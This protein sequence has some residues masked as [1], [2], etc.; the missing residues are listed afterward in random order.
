MNPFA[1]RFPDTCKW[2]LVDGYPIGGG[3]QADIYRVYNRDGGSEVYALKL[4]KHSDQ[5]ARSR[6]HREINA[7]KNLD[8]PRVMKV[9]DS[10]TDGEE[11]Q[12]YVMPF[13]YGARPLTEVIKSDSNPFK[14]DAVR[15]IQMFIQIL[16]GLQECHTKEIVHRDLSPNNV[17]LLPDKS[18]QIID[19]GICQQ[20]SDSTLTTTNEGLG[21]R[22][23]NA[24]ECGAGASLPISFKSDLYSAAKILWSV[25]VGAWAFERETPVFGRC[26]MPNM[27]PGNHDCWH[28]HEIFE[29][30]IRESP[31]DRLLSASHALQFSQQLLAVIQRKLTPFAKIPRS[32]STCGFGN[33]EVL[34]MSEQFH[35]VFGKD[36]FA[37]RCDRCGTVSFRDNEMWKKSF[38]DRSKLR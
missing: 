14:G 7:L 38:E 23:Y 6:F 5:K 1:P 26:S 33:P 36:V 15:S 35:Q 10:S 8:H 2:A 17:L 16:E 31:E 34:P 9:T 29:H 24:P 11:F 37:F 4:L 3:W 12:F 32:C 13:L 18:V 21:T 20:S 19:F 27:F 22:C 25:V 28:L 30:T